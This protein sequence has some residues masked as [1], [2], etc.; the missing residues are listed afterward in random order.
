MSQLLT[1]HLTQL[2]L[3][4]KRVIL[5]ADLNVPL[6]NG[7]VA[8][9]F[10]IKALLP[11]INYILEH[12][13]K[14]TLLTHLGRPKGHDPKFSTQ[15]IAHWFNVHGYT[16][17]LL[18]TP[19]AAA[20]KPNAQ[21]TMLEN[22]RFFAGEKNKDEAFAQQLATLGDLY[23]ND[24]FGVLHRDD[25]SVTVLPSLFKPED[26]T[27]GFLVEQELKALS[28]L[29]DSPAEPF[30]FIVGGGKVHDKLPLIEAMLP[31][32]HTILFC[33]AIS[34]TVAKALGKGVGK[35]LVDEGSLP[36][37]AEF[38]KKAFDRNVRLVIP[39]DY[40]VAQGNLQGPLSCVCADDFPFD[41]MAITI[42]PCTI[43]C[44][45]QEIQNAKT[46]FFNG[47]PG[48]VD[49]PKTLQGVAGI[50]KA[51]GNSSGF[52]V[53][54]GG[55]SVAA[56]QELGLDDRIDYLSTGG[57]ASLAYLAGQELP[58]LK[59]FIHASH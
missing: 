24:A 14:I 45:A 13:A 55:D 10:K 1:S 51:M 29:I 8:N 18:A 27:I 44:Y 19:D 34:C 32:V 7:I 28:R 3:E 46:I 56:A 21:I 2:P 22:L 40:Q 31:R 42:G 38:I 54:G 9:D 15:P 58:G 39:S 41:D 12:G 30:V 16:T 57:G 26:R 43:D 48:F 6:H 23:V 20:I 47:L 36:A 4:N 52:S 59:V 33:P 35:S 53:I 25:T 11:T 17:S 5:R 49:R 37:V 50:F